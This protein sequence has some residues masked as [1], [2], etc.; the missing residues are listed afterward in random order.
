M[1]NGGVF[2]LDN[3]SAVA[4]EMAKLKQQCEDQA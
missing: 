1:E 4:N 3:H 2:S